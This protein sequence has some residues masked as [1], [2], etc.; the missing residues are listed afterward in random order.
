MDRAQDRLAL[1]E[2]LDRDGRCLRAL[3]VTAW[4]L[5]IGRALDNDVV[6]DDPH[7]A[8]RHASLEADDG[9]AVRLRVGD[10]DNG[11]I[12]AG[13]RLSRGQ[14]AE[15]PRSAS[16]F[17]VGTT[18]LRL[19]LRGEKL[20]AERPLPSRLPGV[21]LQLVATGVAV[22]VLALVVHGIALDPGADATA[23]LPAVV[24]LPGAIAAWCG[25][26]ALLS[27][28]FQHRFDFVGHLRIALPWL[29][30]LEL[31]DTLLPQAAAA[32]G[33]VT[34]WRLGTPLE[35]L[36]LALMIH[37]HL[38]HLVPMHPRAVGISVT[39]LA[40]AGG[41]VSLALTQR[42]TD[43][44]SRPPYMSTLPL[45]MLNIASRAPVSAIVDD[46][47]PLADRLAERVRSGRKA[48]DGDGDAADAEDSD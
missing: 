11:V 40:L 20:A 25:L 15:V 29:L 8:A 23:W 16:N 26:W 18:R 27:K 13:R 28:L 24:F 33:A 46:M 7:V 45:P 17:L 3:D 43:R 9:G 38:V 41:A 36:M 47:V 10:S 5:S 37:R 4:P 34:L 2:V 1:I 42:A 32:L 19:R 44:F 35:A 21:D 22:F 31:I 12:L 14:A 39:A 48:E 6:L 30:A